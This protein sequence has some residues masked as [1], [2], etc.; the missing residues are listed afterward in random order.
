MPSQE[1][2]GHV[3]V[4][5][6]CLGLARRTAV[7][8]MFIRGVQAEPGEQRS[9]ICLLGVSMPSQENSGHVYAYQGCLWWARRIAVMYMFIR[10]VYVEPGE[11]RSCICLLGV[12]R[13]SQE[14][15][16]H[17]YVYQGCLCRGRR[18]AVM[19]IR[20]CPFCLFVLL[21]CF[22]QIYGLFHQYGI[23]CFSFY[24]IASIVTLLTYQ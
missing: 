19:F 24:Y 1:N 6:G 14:N 4:Y 17:V 5:Q 8:C 11:Q 7:M 9:C 18:I 10:G 12:S 3:Y 22:Y 15:N 21:I 16:G 20:G 13:P 23:F 2:S